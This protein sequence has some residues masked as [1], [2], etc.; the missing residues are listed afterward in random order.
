[1]LVG[2]VEP[3]GRNVGLLYDVVPFV[4]TEAGV[5]AEFDEALLLDV[6]FDAEGEI[7]SDTVGNVKDGIVLDALF[8]ADVEDGRR[9]QIDTVEVRDHVA[10]DDR[11]CGWTVA[12]LELFA[13]QQECNPLEANP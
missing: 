7:E 1:M 6:R 2:L 12:Y 9:T 13:V 3:L 8:N 11:S 5:A 10:Q 4:E